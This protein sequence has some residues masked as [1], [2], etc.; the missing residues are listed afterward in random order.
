MADGIARA[1]E[2][3]VLVQLDLL[4]V[5]SESGTLLVP[6]RPEIVVEVS[7]DEG[8]LVIDPPEGLLDL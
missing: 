2:H 7:V 6:Y 8:R 1:V 5:R 3:L 4:E